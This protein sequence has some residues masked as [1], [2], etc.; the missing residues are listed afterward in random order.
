M[1]VT[2]RVD[3]VAAQASASGLRLRPTGCLG[4]SLEGSLLSP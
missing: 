2:F 3:K 4:L 1:G